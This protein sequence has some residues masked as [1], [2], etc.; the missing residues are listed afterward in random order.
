MPAT[1][2][3]FHGSSTCCTW[4][5]PERLKGETDTYIQLDGQFFQVGTKYMDSYSF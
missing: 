1:S 2:V 4:D 5:D 3:K